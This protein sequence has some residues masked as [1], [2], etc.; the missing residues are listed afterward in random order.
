MID[1][2]ALAAMTAPVLGWAMYVERRLSKILAIKEQ[3]D[4]VEIQVDKLVDHLIT[5]N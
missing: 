2:P 3:V 4:K 1:F 5:K